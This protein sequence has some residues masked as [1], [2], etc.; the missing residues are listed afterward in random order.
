MAGDGFSR[1]WRALFLVPAPALPAPGTSA[2]QAGGRVMSA[3][4]YAQALMFIEDTKAAMA[5]AEAALEGEVS[6]DTIA[7]RKKDLGQ[8][9]DMLR[10]M[11]TAAAQRDRIGA[12]GLVT[13][14]RAR[15]T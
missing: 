7:A 9:L 4:E 3:G 14:E 6:G 2:A 8:R 5:E 15:A 1:G 13:P 12:R 10:R 11:M